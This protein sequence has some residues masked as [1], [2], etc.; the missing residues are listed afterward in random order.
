MGWRPGPGKLGQKRENIP[1]SCH[2]PQKTPNLKRKKFFFD[3]N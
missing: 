1:A 3:L 2:H